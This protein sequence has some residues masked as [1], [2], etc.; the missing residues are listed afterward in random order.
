MYLTQNNAKLIADYIIDKIRSS[1]PIW[2]QNF[3]GRMRRIG[4][5]DT[6]TPDY[7]FEDLSTKKTYALFYK[8]A[9]RNMDYYYSAVNAAVSVLSR[10]DYCGLILPRVS[11]GISIGMDVEAK[12]YDDNLGRLPISI[13]EYDNDLL[14]NNIDMSISLSKPLGNNINTS[15]QKTK[16][17]RK[18]YW[19]WWRD[20]S[21]HEVFQLLQLSN[22][23][24]NESG[25]IYTKFIYPE[26]Y[27]MMISGETRQWD[28][29]PR[30]KT[31][32][33]ASFKSEKQNYKI[34]LCQ[35]GLWD[36]LNGKLTLKGKSLL[37]LANLYGSE[38]SKYF[39]SLAKLIL[40]DGKHLDLI[41]DVVEFQKSNSSILP[42]T[43]EEFFTLLDFF[44]TDKNSIGTRK[45][46]AIKTGAKKTYVRDE[47]K[48]WNKLGLVN[49]QANKRYFKPYAGIEFNWDRIN[50]ILLSTN[51]PMEE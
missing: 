5:W 11:N 12:I 29:T 44:L 24:S 4:D 48:L 31:F 6:P 10:H 46:S 47:P 23:Y 16:T 43:S 15:I 25:D 33:K 42:E 2:I 50:D 22:K 49:I 13:I 9:N 30:K 45:P 36:V 3:S 28:G 8:E 7:V 19:C 14:L 17:E 1:D 21:H 39:K 26:F 51:Y 38:S 40:V 37:S 35:L 34:P 18:S 27:N 20:A 41:K 32:S